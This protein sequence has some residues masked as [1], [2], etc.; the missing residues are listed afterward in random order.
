MACDYRDLNAK[1]VH[2]AYAPPAAKQLFDLLGEAQVYSTHDC[3]WGYHQFRWQEDAIPKTAIRTHLGTFE[4]LVVHFGTTSAPAQWTRLMETILRP[5]LGKFVIIFLDD[6]CVY[7][8]TAE[9]HR[10]NVWV[11]YR[12]LAKNSIYLR[13]C[14]CY[15]F[16]RTIKYLGWIISNGTLTPDPE[17]V[18]ALR[19]WVIPDSKQEVRS[20]TGFCNFYKRLIPGYSKLMAPLHDLQR[21]EIPNSV[22]AFKNQGCWTPLHTTAFRKFIVTMT[23]APVVQ[24]ARPDLPY[25]LET[26]AS[27]VAVGE[28]LSQVDPATGQKFDVEYYSRRLSASQRNYEP[29]K[30]ELL[31]LIVCL[32]RTSPDIA[33]WGHPGESP[34]SLIMNHS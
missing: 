23:E 12:L 34:S 14:K 5:Y 31:A 17:K 3:T 8:K 30:L 4:F 9:E 24:I 2:E 27:E 21:D 10:K 16:A 28:I 6:L 33:S 22:E 20:F 29:Y 25:V 18:S 7:S 26:D 19:N 11:V 13:F 32:Q 1:L 15:F